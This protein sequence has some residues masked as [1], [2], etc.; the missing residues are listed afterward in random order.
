MDTLA[1]RLAVPLIGPAEVFHLLALL[2]H[3]EGRKYGIS[4]V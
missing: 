1:V 3:F 2:P 4:T